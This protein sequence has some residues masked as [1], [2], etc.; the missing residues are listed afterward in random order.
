MKADKPRIL[1]GKPVQVMSIRQL[2]EAGLTGAG[3]LSVAVITCTNRQRYIDSVFANYLRQKYPNK[4]LCIVLNDETM[5]IDDWVEKAQSYPDIQ[6]FELSSQVSLGECF[7][8]G[9]AQTKSSYV[10]KFDDDDYYAPHFLDASLAVARSTKA[11]IVGKSCRFVYFELDST[12]A[13]Y[14]GGGENQA[15]EYVAG[16]TMVIKRDVF[17]RLRFPDINEGDDSQF[18]KECLK[19]GFRIYSG[20]RY[21][22]VTVRRADSQSHTF[23]ITHEEYLGL[24][25]I[26]GQIRDYAAYCTG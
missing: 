11:D 25:S 20:D 6:V 22:Y 18:Q 4:E 16:A 24:C 8:F 23:Q 1:V 17:K 15:V 7:N 13:I 19:Q 14:E 2:K 26:I 9:V 21:N 5:P 3:M 12:L 10:A